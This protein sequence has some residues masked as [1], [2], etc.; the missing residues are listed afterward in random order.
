MFV[1]STLGQQLL[2]AQVLSASLAGFVVALRIFCK[3]R[4]K[5]GVRADDYWILVG[6]L[7][8]YTATGIV[9]RGVSFSHPKQ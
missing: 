9:L 6:L 1:F 7:C 4:Y 8:Y 3:I 5:Q 2:A